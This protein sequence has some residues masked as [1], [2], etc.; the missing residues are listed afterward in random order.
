MLQIYDDKLGQKGGRRAQISS[1]ERK[2]L[3]EIHPC[4]ISQ[5]KQSTICF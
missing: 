5:M 4:L 2:L 3:Y 1:I